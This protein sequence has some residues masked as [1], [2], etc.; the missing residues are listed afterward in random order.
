MTSLNQA[1]VGK[2][3][4]PV[5]IPVVVGFFSLLCVFPTSEKRN[6][7]RETKVSVSP[8]ALSVSVSEKHVAS[9]AVSNS[10]EIIDP[11]DNYRSSRLAAATL[12]STLEIAG[13]CCSRA[14]ESD[15]N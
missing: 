9:S 8:L 14:H 12:L 5:F 7:H 3:G 15:F 2:L 13:C 11:T 10:P 1:N 4:S 6:Q